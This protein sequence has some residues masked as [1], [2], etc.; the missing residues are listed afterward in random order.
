[1]VHATN[2]QF[3]MHPKRKNSFLLVALFVIIKQGTLDNFVHLCVFVS[4]FLWL[5]IFG[6]DNQKLSVI[7]K[8]R[9][10]LKVKYPTKTL[11]ILV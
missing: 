2:F 11:A 6:T 10:Q 3:G 8:M 7:E 4:Q 1:M 9:P 5:V